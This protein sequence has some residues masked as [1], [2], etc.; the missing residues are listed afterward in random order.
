MLVMPSLGDHWWREMIADQP[1]YDVA[2]AALDGG[3]VYQIE[4]DAESEEGAND[5]VARCI[6]DPEPGR[7]LDDRVGGFFARDAGGVGRTRQHH[8]AR[9]A[10]IAGDVGESGESGERD[11]D[12][13]QGGGRI[14]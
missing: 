6:G 5:L 4:S 11:L 13:L 9:Q 7:V 12:V 10:V 8:A 14:A 3:V 1:R 2:D